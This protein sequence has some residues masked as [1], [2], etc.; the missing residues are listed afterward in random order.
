MLNNFFLI[1]KK[2]LKIVKNE[3]K[4]IVNKR[5]KKI[6]KNLADNLP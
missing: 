5:L 4:K 6:V 2:L 3:V 1:I